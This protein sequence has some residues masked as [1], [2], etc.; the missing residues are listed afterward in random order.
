MLG[1]WG[2]MML[3]LLSHLNLLELKLLG[4]L[5]MPLLRILVLDLELLALMLR[6]IQLGTHTNVGTP[7]G[8]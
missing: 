5:P 7:I 3:K 2:I 6:G 4:Q 8:T 1:I